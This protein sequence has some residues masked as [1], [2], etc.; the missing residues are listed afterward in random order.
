MGFSKMG[1]YDF[2]NRRKS[3]KIVADKGLTIPQIAA[4]IHKMNYGDH[5]LLSALV[6]LRRR[7]EKKQ[8]KHFKGMGYGVL[9]PCGELLTDAI[10]E[11]LDN[12]EF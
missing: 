5:R 4:M 11:Q 1:E 8:R 2:L 9:R 12:G 3:E 6:S 10:K 7:D